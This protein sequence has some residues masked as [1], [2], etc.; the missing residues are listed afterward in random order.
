MTISTYLKIL[1]TINKLVF[2][3]F[4][5]ICSKIQLKLHISKQILM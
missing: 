1:V 2:L 5:D 4:I 3:Q